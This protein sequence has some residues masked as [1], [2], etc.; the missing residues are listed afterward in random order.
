MYCEYFFQ[1][2]TC[3][4]IFLNLFF[5]FCL[6]FC[7]LIFLLVV[8]DE[9]HFFFFSFLVLSVLYSTSLPRPWSRKTWSVFSSRSFMVCFKLR[10]MIHLEI[11]FI[12][13]VFFLTI[14]LSSPDRYGSFNPE[15]AHYSLWRLMAEDSSAAF[16]K[17]STERCCHL[18]IMSV[19]P[20]WCLTESQADRVLSLS[21]IS[22][23]QS[24]F[25]GLPGPGFKSKYLG[26]P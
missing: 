26:K 13:S 5:L 17:H 24:H 25:Q 21:P 1:S 2:V 12:Y 10:P 18:F 19:P 3:L 22:Y 6:P 4:L 11:M 23:L 14:T 16:T 20:Q 7:L 8:L 9:L 15:D